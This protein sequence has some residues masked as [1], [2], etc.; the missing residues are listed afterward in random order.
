M[1]RMEH[2]SERIRRLRESLGMDKK[3]LADV[4]DV[5]LGY[6]Y[7]L[8]KGEVKSPGYFTVRGLA[9]ALHVGV[10][11]LMGEEPL[12]D[13]LWAAN[14]L[15]RTIHQAAPNMSLSDVVTWLQLLNSLTA[16]ERALVL[17]TGRQFLGNRNVRTGRVAET[18]AEYNPA[19]GEGDEKAEG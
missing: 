13:S 5:E 17:N 12:P 6:I 18:P 9:K 10:D 14:E 16:V 7:R 8:E 11:E 15:Y 2:Y 19:Q 4:S 1:W 3:A